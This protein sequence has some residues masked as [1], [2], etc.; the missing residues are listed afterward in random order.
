MDQS[1]S[2]WG[3]KHVI[4][5]M[6]TRNSLK[7][8]RLSF[9][10]RLSTV[11]PQETWPH[12]SSVAKSMT[13]PNISKKI[14]LSIYGVFF[15][16]IPRCSR[17]RVLNFTR[18]IFSKI[19]FLILLQP[20]HSRPTKSIF[21]SSHGLTTMKSYAHAWTRLITRRN[22]FSPF[23]AA[24]KWVWLDNRWNLRRSWWPPM[25]RERKKTK[26]SNQNRAFSESRLRVHWTFDC[27][28]TLTVFNSIT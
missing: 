15:L 11:T 10:S 1:Q 16:S 26:N 19:N 12:T 25:K 8:T 5:L 9:K 20:H 21:G 28:I 2:F 23:H 13:D 6:P 14:I 27:S 3:L 24:S 17:K 4:M 18:D 22:F 7:V